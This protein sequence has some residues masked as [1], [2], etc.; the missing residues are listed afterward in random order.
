MRNVF[1]A[2]GCILAIEILRRFKD[3]EK[4]Y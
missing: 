4:G 1:K 2:L 3:I